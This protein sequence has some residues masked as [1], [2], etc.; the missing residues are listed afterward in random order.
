MVER[1]KNK[2]DIT[3][4]HL[5]LLAYGVKDFCKAVGISPRMFYVLV[6]R[7]DGPSIVRIGRR[8]LITTTAAEEWLA[9]HQ[10]EKAA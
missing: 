10:L 3:P 4:A 9:A 2:D 5:R 8:T 7:G 6:A 1:T